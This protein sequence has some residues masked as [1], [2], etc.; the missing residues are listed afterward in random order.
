M[1]SKPSGLR[2]PNAVKSSNTN[3]ASSAGASAGPETPAATPKASGGS[4]IPMSRL[5][6]SNSIRRKITTPLGL[7]PGSKDSGLAMDTDNF[8]IGDV[9]YVNGDTSKRGKITFIGDVGFAKGEFA[10]ISLDLPV[11]NHDGLV[12][13]KRYFQCAPAHGLFTKL[14]RLTRE[15][16]L[17]PPPPS[18]PRVM[19][20]RSYTVASPTLPPHTP[21]MSRTA[22]VEERTPSPSPAR[23]IIAPGSSLIIGERVIVASATGGTKIGL[24]RY[25]GSTEFQTGLWAGVE[26]LTPMGKNNGTVGGKTYFTCEDNYGLF[27]PAHKVISSPVNKTPRRHGSRESLMSMS[28]LASSAASRSIRRSLP[29]DSQCL[30]TCSLQAVLS[31][32]ENHLERILKERELDRMD[33]ENLSRQYEEK[34]SEVKKLQAESVVF[35]Q[36]LQVSVEDSEA[37]KNLQNALE[38]EKRKVEDLQYTLDEEKIM[39]ADLQVQLDILSSKSSEE[40]KKSLELSRVESEQFSNEIETLKAQSEAF[41]LE[42]KTIEVKLGEAYSKLQ[43][44]EKTVQELTDKAKALMEE[45]NAAQLAQN[46]LVTSHKDQV[47]TLTKSATDLNE[48]STKAKQQ[49][50]EKKRLVDEL[51]DKQLKLEAQYGIV[52]DEKKALEAEVVALITKLEEKSNDS[53]DVS[54][55]MSSKIN[56]LTAQVEDLRLKLESSDEDKAL[57]RRINAEF[58]SR[59]AQHEQIV[60]TLKKEAEDSKQKLAEEKADLERKLTEMAAQAEQEKGKIEE[61]ISAKSA[62]LSSLQDQIQA[63]KEEISSEKQTSENLA[64]EIVQLRSS[65]SAAKT[66]MG[67]YEELLTT[68]KEENLAL[69]AEAEKT[70]ILFKEK[71]N[72]HLVQLD[73]VS[74][75]LADSAEENRVIR[76]ELASVK[77]GY[78]QFRTTAE[79]K[80]MKIKELED[81]VTTLKQVIEKDAAGL[82]KL[83]K[84]LD[85][86][87]ESLKK[88]KHRL[89]EQVTAYQ[90]D[91]RN[92]KEVEQ[93]LSAE[94]LS[95]R[96]RLEQTSKTIADLE[97]KLEEKKAII[98]SD[99]SAK[100]DIGDPQAHIAFLNS[101]IA[102]LQAKIEELQIKVN[103]LL[104]GGVESDANSY[105]NRVAAASGSSTLQSLRSYCDICEKFD[106]HDTEECPTQVSDDNNTHHGALR[107]ESRPYCQVCEIFGHVAGECD[108]QETF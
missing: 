14:N 68:A 38:E 57:L 12:Q 17:E 20:T 86:K 26:L 27:V 82:D 18:T 85:E 74:C 81:E 101:V 87:L 70:A 48:T 9:V 32:K 34:L 8:I 42:K 64:Q 75:K 49:L 51:R 71:I 24:L 47:A 54:N 29:R 40:S 43:S 78:E 4:A 52:H 45:L 69:K 31:E 94:V 76:E 107:G 46:N 108:D 98:E 39:K 33:Y 28:S 37:V 93:G 106:S 100:L 15:P 19:S 1:A 66:Q 41:L 96:N 103:V 50:D 2:Q 61:R 55:V 21:Q 77:T 63:M 97:K 5:P 16:T 25:L 88:D 65:T 7:V 36:R 90:T 95:L 56:D 35:Q 10:G 72:K 62:E 102:G 53:S 84:D 80:T 6:S 58:K 30:P 105:V 83:K 73:D 3:L 44:S 92:F 89:K 99:K 67:N 79:E 104:N 13:G 23:S 60:S 22:S 11:G 91:S 59:I